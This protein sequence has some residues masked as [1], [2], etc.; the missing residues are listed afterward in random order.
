MRTH[1]FFEISVSVCVFLYVFIK[2]TALTTCCNS[3]HWCCKGSSISCVCRKEKIA[4][5]AISHA[6]YKETQIWTVEESLFCLY[7]CL[8]K[9][10]DLSGTF[11][12]TFRL[13]YHKGKA[14]DIFGLF[15]G[16]LWCPFIKCGCTKVNSKGT[17]ASCSTYLKFEESHFLV[18]SDSKQGV[19]DRM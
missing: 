13:L 17:S 19:Y 14:T 6:G 15:L 16:C 7:Q 1:I 11:H 10:G 5:P 2:L 9:T 3:Q 4:L 12:Y 8:L 18:Q